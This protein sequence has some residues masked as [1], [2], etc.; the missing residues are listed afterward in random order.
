MPKK[1]GDHAREGWGKGKKTKPE[2]CLCAHSIG[3]N[4]V[5]LNWPG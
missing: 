5:I 4:K 2:C 1:G 3:M